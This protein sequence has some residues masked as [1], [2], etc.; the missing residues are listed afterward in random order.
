MVWCAL[1]WP[2]EAE[3]LRR[4]LDRARLLD[5]RCKATAVADGRIALPLAVDG[6]TEGEI[7][8]RWNRNEPLVLALLADTEFHQR[9]VRS[10]LL[11]ESCRR[12]VE[13]GVAENLANQ[14]LRVLPKHWEKLG[15]IVLFAGSSEFEQVCSSRFVREP[16]CE[17][18]STTLFSFSK[19]ARNIAVV[20]SIQAYL[21]VLTV[22]KMRHSGVRH[23]FY[24]AAR[25]ASG[26]PWIHTWR[27]PSWSAGSSRAK[28]SQ[29]ERGARTLVET[30]LSDSA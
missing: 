30:R 24:G 5:L 26:I 10:M 27:E 17:H 16:V 7:Q 1:V 21:V 11:S 3:S 8:Q 23:S 9:G 25:S 19:I 13:A 14:V 22:F 20:S 2:A 12:L 6:L 15:D 18:L 28:P 4:A 29:E